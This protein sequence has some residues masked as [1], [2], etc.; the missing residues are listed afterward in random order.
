MKRRDFLGVALAGAALPPIAQAKGN[1]DAALRAALDGLDAIDSPAAKL[2]SL[3]RFDPARLSPSPRL[4]LETVRAGLAIDIRLAARFRLG[5]SPYAVSRNAGAWRDA[6]PEK[7]A[8]KLAARI[9]KDSERI[10]ADAGRGFILPTGFLDATVTAIAAAAQKAPVRVAER[11]REQA[12]LLGGLRASSPAEPGVGRLPGGEEYFALLL[13]RHF[14]AR[15]APAEAHRRMLETA[16]DLTARADTVLRRL[17]MTKGPVG[18]RIGA[19]FRDPRWLYSDD[20]AGRDR[21]V[22]EMNLWLDRARRRVPALFGPVPPFCLDVAVRRMPREEEAAGRQGYRTLPD[23]TKT[24]AYLVDLQRIRARPAWSLPGVV[25]HELLPGHMIQS[26]IEAEAE[27]HPLRAEYAPAFPEGWAIYAEQLMRQDG[28][29]AGNDHALLGHLHWLLFRVGRGLIDTGIHAGRYAFAR[30]RAT[31]VELQGEP[32]YF[33]SFEQDIERICLEPGVRAAEALTW[34]GLAQLG[35]EAKRRGP[36]ALR[37]FH[38]QVL[39][40]GRKRFERIENGA[41]PV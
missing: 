11:L 29:F 4:D 6:G 35:G 32:G 40:D 3:A 13:E 36:P 12:D 18:A 7:D 33:A 1:D 26:P 21:A 2:G 38:Q 22:A 37:R 30:A 41:G 5:R 25:H 8:D 17:G 16:R 14:G 24:G 39:R 15:I 27:M 10:R 20:D 28:A 23:R 31:L 34:L 19:A 9:A